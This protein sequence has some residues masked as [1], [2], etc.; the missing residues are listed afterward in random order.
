MAKTIKYTGT[1]DRW[2][3]LPVT[4]SQAIWRT[5]QQ[6]S[7]SDSE[8]AQLLATGLFAGVGDAVLALPARIKKSH[9]LT[10]S[11][12]G[13]LSTGTTS[14]ASVPYTHHM[15][16]EISADFTGVR[17]GIPNLE[18]VAITGVTASVAVTSSTTSLINPTVGTALTNDMITGWVQA[19]FSGSNSVT[20]P[21][22]I[23]A[24][25]P[26]ITYS[27]WVP[28]KSI[29]RSDGGTLP[30]LMIRQCYPTGTPNFSQHFATANV[31]FSAIGAPY[32]KATRQ[33][34]DG[35][36][37][38]AT[39][40]NASPLNTWTVGPVQVRSNRQGVNIA[41]FGDSLTEGQ[42]G[43]AIDLN[44]WGLRACNQLT[45]SS[46]PVSCCNLGWSGGVT[47][48]FY[49]RALAR[50]SELKPEIAYMSVWSPNDSSVTAALTNKMIDRAIDFVNACEAAGVIPALSTCVPTEGSGSGAFMTAV[51]AF[52]RDI[53]SAGRVLVLDFRAVLDSDPSSGGGSGLFK[54]G[55]KFDSTHPNDVGIDAMAAEAVSKLQ[56]Y[57][58]GY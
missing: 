3:E 37:S 42:P 55:M 6:E 21:A 35:V 30:L 39:F 53:G 4:G 33:G 10:R 41:F 11:A 45:A 46:L 29:A 50:L 43:P 24:N 12:R 49:T 34:V 1:Q 15:L 13:K 9:Q 44:S 31:D 58:R 23:A 19:T 38:P 28:L 7:R 48:D 17:F 36:A 18:T 22:R 8:A 25:V 5:G 32:F 14:A 27:D 51:D 40:T 20:L 16:M 47:A 52:V 56:G 26:S 57:I 2:A 54:S